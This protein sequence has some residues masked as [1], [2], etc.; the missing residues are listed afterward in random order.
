MPW[1]I[2]PP[3]STCVE[4]DRTVKALRREPMQKPETGEKAYD[5][6]TRRALRSRR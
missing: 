1:S 4:L 2:Y 6:T 3:A 5:V